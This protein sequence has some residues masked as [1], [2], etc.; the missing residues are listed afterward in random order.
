[1]SLKRDSMMGRERIPAV[2]PARIHSRSRGSPRAYFETVASFEVDGHEHARRD[3][4]LPEYTERGKAAND[5]EL[6]VVR[7]PGRFF[8]QAF[9]VLQFHDQ[10]HGVFWNRA[11][12][13]SP[14]LTMFFARR[15]GGRL[16]SRDHRS[17]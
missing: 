3:A 11:S 15:A 7:Q 6:R 13:Q 5:Y 4:S 14:R 10:L 9:Q 8:Q 17:M 2:I 12:S 16:R 1:M